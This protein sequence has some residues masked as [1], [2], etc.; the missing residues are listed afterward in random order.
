MDPST[1]AQAQWPAA[2]A[3]VPHAD[4][5]KQ[6][7]A[8]PQPMDIDGQAHEW[9]HG[10]LRTVPATMVYDAHVCGLS[11]CAERPQLQADAQPLYDAHRNQLCEL[12][13]RILSRIKGNPHLYPPK[14]GPGLQCH[15]CYKKGW[16]AKQAARPVSTDAAPPAKRARRTQSDPGEPTNL[17]RKRIRAQPPTTVPAP[18]KTRVHTPAVDPS[19]LLDQQHAQRLALLAAEKIDAEPDSKAVKTSAAHPTVSWSVLLCE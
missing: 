18:K 14:V 16:L 11:V 5:G 15:P 2:A 13:K 6:P 10:Q 12:C 8:D 7:E 19:L 4:E 9:T 17:T 1:L 3:G